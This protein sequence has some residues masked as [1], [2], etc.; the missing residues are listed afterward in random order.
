MEVLLWCIGV[1]VS[2]VEMGIITTVLPYAQIVLSALLIVAILLQQ[3]SANA[4][5]ALGGSDALGT[6]NTRR[7]SE[8]FLFNSTIVLAILFSAFALLA[9][10]LK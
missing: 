1:C 3:T 4:G 8:K 2:M 7:G 6:Y 5:G 9:L 10:L